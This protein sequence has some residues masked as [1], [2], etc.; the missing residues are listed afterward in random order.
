MWFKFVIAGLAVWRLTHLLAHEDG[1]GDVF[2]RL[3]RVFPSKLLTC[4]FCLSVWIALPFAF[5]VT[6]NWIERAVVWWALSGAAMIIEKV[7]RQD[8]LDIQLGED[9]HELLRRDVERP[10]HAESEGH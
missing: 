5:F 1:P 8:T 9:D 2:K 6:Y 10:D 3:R 4:F 7:T